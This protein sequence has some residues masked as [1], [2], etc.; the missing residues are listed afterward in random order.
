VSDYIRCDPNND[1]KNNLADAVWIVNE[2]IRNGPETACPAAADCNADGMED[3]SDAVYAVA[4]QFQG[5]DPPPAP[6]PG[7][8]GKEE[9]APEDCPAGSTLCP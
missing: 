8:G 3:L 1:G 4:Y 2:L 5:G 9:I 7:C 6:F